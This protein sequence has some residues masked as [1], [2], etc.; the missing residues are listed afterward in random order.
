MLTVVV[1]VLAGVSV[2]V[3]PLG[4]VLGFAMPPPLFF[5]VLVLIT[6]TYLAIVHVLKRYLYA[7]TGLTA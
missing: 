1:G 2:V 6:V 7:S 5:G 3:S 4:A